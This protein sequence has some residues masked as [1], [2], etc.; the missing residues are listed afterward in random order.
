M[1]IEAAA[2]KVQS[3]INLRMAINHHS[4]IAAER[5]KETIDVFVT[6]KMGHLQHTYHPLTYP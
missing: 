2:W 1:L 4:Q 3:T 6:I 5:S